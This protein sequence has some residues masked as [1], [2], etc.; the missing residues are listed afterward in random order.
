MS[1]QIDIDPEETEAIIDGILFDIT[2]NASNYTNEFKTTTCVSKGF[3]EINTITESVDTVVDSLKAYIREIIDTSETGLPGILS[4]IGNFINNTNNGT[5]NNDIDSYEDEVRQDPSGKWVYTDINGEKHWFNTKEDAIAYAKDLNKGINAFADPQEEVRR[6]QR[7]NSK[8][9][10][11]EIAPVEN[12]VKRG[13]YGSWVY[14]D[15]QGKEHSFVTKEEAVSAFINGVEQAHVVKNSNGEYSIGDEPLVKDEDGNYHYYKKVYGID[16]SVEVIDYIVNPHNDTMTKALDDKVDINTV[17]TYGPVV[18]RVKRGPYGSWIYVDKQG[19]EH[20]F[21]TEEG[22]VSASVNGVEQVH[23]EGNTIDGY[24]I[25]GVPLEKDDDGNFIYKKTD[26]NSGEEIDYIVNPNN[27]TMTR[28]VDVDNVNTDGSQ[29]SV[30]TET[31]ATSGASAENGQTQ[32]S[33]NPSKQA[34]PSN[35]STTSEEDS[36]APSTGTETTRTRRPSV[37]N[38]QTQTSGTSSKDS[39]SSQT[40]TTSEEDSSAPSTGTET[41]TTSGSSTSG[42]DEYIETFSHNKDSDNNGTSTDDLDEF[43]EGASQVSE[44]ARENGDV[45]PIPTV[46]GTDIE[47]IVEEVNNGEK[48]STVDFPDVEA[49]TPDLDIN[50]SLVPEQT[51]EINDNEEE[52]SRLFKARGGGGKT[53]ER[54]K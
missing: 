15:D 30:E 31:T 20:S 8:S 51:E 16:N 12:R 28:A 33:D 27:E 46:A 18:K 3:K 54:E 37:E 53:T 6:R 39:T 32:T 5:T 17:D 38:G 49:D 26:D 34:N 47:Q 10:T 24:S 13:P 36:S 25:D 19:K 52:I 7:E 1:E 41:T 23:V 45:T 4:L 42:I 44:E 21:A 35:T 50:N 40:S 43:F 22:A 9:E 2:D 11:K 29:S 14:V 48:M